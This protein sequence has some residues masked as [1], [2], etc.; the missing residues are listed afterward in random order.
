MNTTLNEIRTHRPT[1]ISQLDCSAYWVENGKVIEGTFRDRMDLVSYAPRPNG[2]GPAYYL[3]KLGSR[4]YPILHWYSGKSWMVEVFS[5]KRE[6]QEV[7]DDIYI[8]EMLDD[9]NENIYADRK[10]AEAELEVE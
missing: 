4:K 1:L 9:S 7:L 10:S 3:E 6:A 8:H 2:T 5:S